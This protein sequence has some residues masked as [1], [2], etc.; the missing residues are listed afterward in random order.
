MK[1]SV[2]LPDRDV[3]F[4]DEYARSHGVPSRSGVLQEAL[5]LL[6]ARALGEAY[7]AAWDEWSS[8]GDD[9]GTAWESALADGLA[10][11]DAA[12]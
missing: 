12:R 6:R 9:D 10:G 1:L 5:A 8:G 3:A 7:E 2:S 4:L 11:A